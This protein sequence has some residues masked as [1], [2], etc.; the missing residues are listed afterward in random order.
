MRKIALLLV[1]ILA[2]CASVGTKVDPAKVATLKP[3]VSTEQDV[4]ATLGQPTQ[5]ALLPD[6]SKA[7][8]Y[9]HATATVPPT[10]FIPLVGPMLGTTE[11]HSDSV[12]LLIGPDGK[13]KAR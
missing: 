11:T 7:L 6:G 8:S 4:I 12:Q 10:F 9:V 1:A 3:G 5:T 13:V 2:G